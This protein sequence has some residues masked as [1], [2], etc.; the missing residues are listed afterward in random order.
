[1]K[2]ELA[3]H[4]QRHSSVLNEPSALP[5]RQSA[6]SLLP[7]II[8]VCY[9]AGNTHY[10]TRIQLTQATNSSNRLAEPYS[11]YPEIRRD[12]IS[13]TMMIFSLGGPQFILN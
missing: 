1:M 5:I 3:V 12:N 7:K 2:K 10:V 8:N 6:N 9:L 11:R 4:H 13:F